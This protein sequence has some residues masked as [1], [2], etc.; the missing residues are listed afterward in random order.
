MTVT[1]TVDP[2]LPLLY[3]ALWTA[4]LAVSARA[5]CL[6]AVFLVTSREELYGRLLGWQGAALW[7]ASATLFSAEA[8]QFGVP[9][10]GLAAWGA[11]L[12]QRERRRGK[13]D[14]ATGVQGMTSR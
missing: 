8:W 3:A 2:P 12:W 9:F 6:L 14:T 4:S 1:V 7:L 11:F 10:A 13:L 5:T